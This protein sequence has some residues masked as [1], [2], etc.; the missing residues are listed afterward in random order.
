MS[1]HL[2]RRVDKLKKRVLHLSG[3]VEEALHDAIRA[4]DERNLELA[5]KVMGGDERIDTL[6]VELEEECL[7]TLALEQPVAFDLRY[8]VAILKM[9]TD[10][11]R[12]G[13]LAVNIAEQARF[14]AGCERIE[15]LPFDLPGMERAVQAMLQQ[16][17]DALVRIDP[18]LAQTVIAGDDH[19]D[20]LYRQMFDHVHHTLRDEPR[21]FE[22]M[23]HYLSIARMLERVA[24]HACNIA[25]DVIYLS[26]GEIWRHR[27]G[28]PVPASE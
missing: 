25:E 12:I 20:A 6:D 21:L 24:D 13:D 18:E 22:T 19:V 9:N 17:L 28:E 15:R 1:L 8:V 5:E 26:R 3:H 16:S 7:S 14:L 27:H 2:Q 4:V 10:L 23:L 11:E